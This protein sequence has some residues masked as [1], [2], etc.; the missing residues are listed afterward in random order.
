M[1]KAEIKQVL[2]NHDRWLDDPFDPRGKFANLRGAD[3]HGADLR[4]ANLH[5][6]NLSGADLS[7]ADLSG[8]NLS[9]ADLSDADIRGADLLDADLYGANLHGADLCGAILNG[10]DL[11]EAN[12]DYSCWPMWCGSLRVKINARIAAQLM[13]H[14]MRAMQSVEEDADVSAVLACKANIR[15]ANRFHHAGFCGAI[16]TP[17]AMKGGA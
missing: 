6:A 17:K 14:A 10:A 9:G 12:I 4:D 1:T 13:Y 8:A 11:N 7:G 3:L 15:L 5:G 2:T 16:V